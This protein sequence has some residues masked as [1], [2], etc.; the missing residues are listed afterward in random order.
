[1]H[2]SRLV[3]HG[4][5]LPAFADSSHQ[6][7]ITQVRPEGALLRIF[8]FNFGGGTPAVTLG[9]V[10]LALAFTTTTSI[11][12]TLP[13]MAPG[14]YLLTLRSTPGPHPGA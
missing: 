1:M 9:G 12:A 2:R 14:T 3:C 11:G 4:T 10:P 13:T 8:G 5:T 6:P 7:L